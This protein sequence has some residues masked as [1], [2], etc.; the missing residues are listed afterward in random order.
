MY[1]SASAYSDVLKDLR[2][3]KSFTVDEYPTI[4]DDYRLTVIQIAESTDDEL[5][6]YVY[7]PSADKNFNATSINIARELDDSTDL[8]FIPYNLEY[9]N[10]A[11]LFFKYR[12]QGFEL[13]KTA[14]RYYN[15]SNILRRFNSDVDEPPSDGQTISEVPNKVAQLWTV[16]T[17]G[18]TVTY[19][20]LTS[21]VITI[22]S[23]V[24]G[25]CY[26]DD[27]LDIGWGAMQ[28][29]TKAYFVAFD[30]DRPIDKLISA[31]LTFFATRVK[32]KYCGNTSKHDH[33]M[34]YDFEDAV[35]ID[36]GTG[37]YNNDPLTITHT[38]KFSNHGGGNWAGRPANR[39]TWNRIRSTEKFIE[40]N[41]NKD[42]Q[43]T[44]GS[45][46]ELSS[47]K[48]VLNFYEAQDKYKINNMWLGFVP[49]VNLING[50]AD[51]EAE[52]NNVFD[53]EILR[54]EFETDGK[55]YNLGVVDNKQT[56]NKQYNDYTGSGC[57]AS[58]EWLKL[59]PWWA[60][61]LIVIFSPLIIFLL[62]KIIVLLITAPFKSIAKRHR[63]R[64]RRKERERKKQ[65][66]AKKRKLRKEVKEA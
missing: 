24:V 27:G 56:G 30:T 18:E 55:H 62:F 21:E 46:S 25:Y 39:Y 57:A 60:W 28:G 23:K 47:T 2:T 43:L 1:A 16:E 33:G 37:V 14:V 7:Q 64:Q 41:N 3:D 20:V 31:D 53:V 35:Y 5:L 8:T 52:L 4:A 10:S 44:A 48:W 63:K 19:T 11:G 32:C 6:I 51:G 15:I 36:Y 17:E 22:T 54:L 65:A 42:H 58:W 61:V 9:L 50:V 34:F 66:K 45:E 49:G 38:Q 59:L 29:L 40:D 13:E 12:V 26:Y